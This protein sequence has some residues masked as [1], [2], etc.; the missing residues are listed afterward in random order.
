M[1]ALAALTLKEV[2]VDALKDATKEVGV[3]AL[4]DSGKEAGVDA[5][6]DSGKE[7]AADVAKQEA[8]SATAKLEELIQTGQPL[9]TSVK[10]TLSKIGSRASA[11]IRSAAESVAK[12]NA[13]TLALG[14]TGLVLAG[15]MIT[16]GISN[17]FAAIA[18]LS[19]E[20]ANSFFITLFGK[21]WKLWLFG[22]AGV[23]MILIIIIMLL[24]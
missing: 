1:S 21:N 3:D 12:A 20:T 23:F 4:K 15:Y 6:K 9:S 19:G 5:L 8:Q 17:P 14:V 16:H 18:R 2:G 10:D 24:K 22:G 11:G 7:A 13:K